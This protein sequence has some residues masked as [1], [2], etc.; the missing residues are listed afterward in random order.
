MCKRTSYIGDNLSQENSARR[1]AQFMLTTTKN[2]KVASQLSI[3]DRISRNKFQ[4]QKRQPFK[5]L[6]TQQGSKKIV[7]LVKQDL[8]FIFIFQIVGF[9]DNHQ[10]LA[11]R[12]N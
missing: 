7:L 8:Y 3:I 6:K 1:L 10:G 9:Y 11:I 2:E 4:K 12:R 5:M